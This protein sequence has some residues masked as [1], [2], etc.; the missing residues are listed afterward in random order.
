MKNGPGIFE[1][2]KWSDVRREVS[3]SS[4]PL[5]VAVGLRARPR[6]PP[7]PLGPSSSSEAPQLDVRCDLENT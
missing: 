6:G 2:N 1:V 3:V 4:Q 5:V 7:D